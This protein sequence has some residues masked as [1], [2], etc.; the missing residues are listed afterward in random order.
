MAFGPE[1]A[2][3]AASGGMSKADIKQWLFDRA[4]IPLSKFSNEGIER[5]F[6]RKLADQFANAPLD[7]PVHMWA[8]PQDLI[9]IVTGGAGKHSQYV[10]TF[11]NTRSVTR[12]LKR[13][14]GELVKSIQEFKRG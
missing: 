12:A 13:A 10:P 1:H 2:A 5:R 3:T 11:G 6:R 7:A 4:T 9:V 14:D 8:K